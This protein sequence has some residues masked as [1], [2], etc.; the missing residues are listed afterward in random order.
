[1]RRP[2]RTRGGSPHP[3]PLRSPGPRLGVHP[4]G[5]SDDFDTTVERCVPAHVDHW[6]DAP[7]GLDSASLWASSLAVPA[8]ADRVRHEHQFDFR[9]PG[10]QV[11]DVVRLLVD[12]RAVRAPGGSSAGTRPAHRRAGHQGVSGGLT[13]R[14]VSKEA[15]GT[16][17]WSAPRRRRPAEVAVTLRPSTELDTPAQASNGSESTS[18]PRATDM[19]GVRDRSRVIRQRS[20]RASRQRSR[21]AVPGG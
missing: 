14:A 12:P 19:R 9:E 16:P 10:R 8:P 6:S 2:H 4:R 18:P 15:P 7:S 21:P 20:H 5:F 3:T 17:G 1:M 13:A 11:D